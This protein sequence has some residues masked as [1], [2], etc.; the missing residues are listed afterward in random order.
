MEL[1]NVRAGAA[2]GQG[3]K[4]GW[5]QSWEDRAAPRLGFLESWKGG[6]LMR[7]EGKE[8]EEGEWAGKGA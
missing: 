1:K 3:G 7:P 5:L 4:A 8:W 2:L 6:D